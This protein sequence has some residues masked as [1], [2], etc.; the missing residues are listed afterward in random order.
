MY[1]KDEE[2]ESESEM[3]R[4]IS[5]LL[6]P[7]FL[8]IFLIGSVLVF[9]AFSSFSEQVFLLSILA[10]VGTELGLDMFVKTNMNSKGFFCYS[11]L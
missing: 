4:E 11:D 5:N 10:I 2:S 7:R 6:R 3:G 9:L 1:E 8:I